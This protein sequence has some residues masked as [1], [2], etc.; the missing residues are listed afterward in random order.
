MP[1]SHRYV[2]L[3]FTTF[4]AGTEKYPDE[5]SYSKYLNVRK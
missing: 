4:L 2:I 3:T 5:Q 1:L